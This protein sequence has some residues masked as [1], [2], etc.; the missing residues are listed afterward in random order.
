MRQ[1][2]FHIPNELWGIPLFGFGLLLAI[3]AIYSVLFLGL[4]WYR[5][6][7]DAEFRSYLP[8]LL[9]LG[10]A[11]ALVM[12]A[13]VGPQ[14]LPIRGYGTMLVVAIVAGVGLAV[15][16]GA[17]VGVHSDVIVS[18]SF[19]TFCG[20]ILGA[21][22]FYIIEY[23]RE[24][25]AESFGKSL[26]AAIN[27]TQ[28]GLVIYGAV[29]GGT[30]STLFFLIKNRLP[31][32]ALGDIVAPSVALGLGLGRLG[33]FLNGCC[34]GGICDLPWAVRFPSPS[35]PFQRQVERGE[36]YLQGLKFST[37]LDDRPVITAVAPGSP[38]AA[39]GVRRGDTIDEIN[40]RRVRTIAE[41][42]SLLLQLAPGEPLA[43]RLAGRGAVR[44]DVPLE[45]ELARPTH[46]TQIYSAIDGV[47]L[48]L[49]LLA[50]HPYRRRDGEIL[51][52]L[53]TIHPLSRFLLEIVRT[54]EPGMFGTGLSIAQVISLALLAGA[55][56]LWLFLRSQPRGT[57]LPGRLVPAN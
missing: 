43:I 5:Y 46:P 2:L 54:D 3:W 47:V 53:L 18:L 13:I 36:I 24:F 57:V 30:I 34:F 40:R 21:R 23:P 16:R 41:A 52:W 6:G 44:W 55:A 38:A 48:C 8:I 9:V 39:H 7:F 33:C 26:L 11:I 20:G 25:E 17:E 51:A 10:V 49:F 45:P 14:G 50:L 12:P 56:A 19:W 28:G 37:A 22:L 4:R 35:P 1:T 32:L 31:V 42:E 15:Y 27:L 29:I